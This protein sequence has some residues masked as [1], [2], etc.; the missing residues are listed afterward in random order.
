M[1]KSKQYTKQET[2]NNVFEHSQ[3]KLDFYRSY[4]WRYLTILLSDAY[5]TK[6]NIFD[7]FCGVGVYDNGG[8]GSPII[9][10]D[11]IKEMNEKF[12][13]K[14][15]TL[16]INDLD[17]ARVDFVSTYISEHYRI[18]RDV[19]KSHNIDASDMLKAVIL[20]IAK[21]TSEEK[22]LVF[23][24]PYGY[25]EI[26]KKDILDI[27]N[28]GKSEIILFLPISNM[29]RFSKVALTDEKNASYAHLQRFIADFFEDK[30]HPILDGNF[31]HQLE[32]IKFIKDALSFNNKYYTA[33]YTIQRDTKNYYALFFLTSHIYGLH[34]I[35][36]TKWKLDENA[37]QG[38]SKIQEKHLF[39]DDFDTD[40]Q[41]KYFLNFENSLKIFLD[42]YKSNKQIYEFTL[43][44]GFQPKHAN[45]ILEKIKGL[46]I[47]E[48]NYKPKARY[49]LLGF[50][51]WK[52]QEIRYRV[53]IK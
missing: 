52:E 40:R 49:Y 51:Y 50:K 23:I 31:E 21:T 18:Q 17:K 25:K 5:T 14:Q 28:A 34:Q 2:Q 41:E 35:V 12:P 30:S 43:K 7:V 36:D 6:I 3:A 33:S 45:M 24:D 15:V 46:L 19:L 1:A 44:E 20:H 11:A 53:K 48:N 10:M 13:T 37:G 16:T 9:A 39:S 38:F 27:M 32:Y 4:L 8:K 29:Y 47:F 26:Y 42:E 22:N